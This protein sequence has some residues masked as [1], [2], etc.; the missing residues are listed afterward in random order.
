MRT[1]RAAAPA[2]GKAAATSLKTAT[3]PK[4]HGRPSLRKDAISSERDVAVF[5][6][7]I[8][9]AFRGQQLERADDARAGVAGLDD[10]V[11]VSAV[12]RDVRV[13]ESRRGLVG[14]PGGG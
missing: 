2:R 1:A 8:A 13:R 5:L 4:A 12:G 6:G 3:R 11:D 9:I 14:E 7:R 10:V